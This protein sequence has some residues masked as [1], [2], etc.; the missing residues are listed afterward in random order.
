M[1]A[2]VTG[3]NGFIGSR[4][5]R[6]LLDQGYAVNGIIHTNRDRVLDTIQSREDRLTL[7][8][9]SSNGIRMAV[10]GVNEVYHLAGYYTTSRSVRDVQRLVRDNLGFTLELYAA[11]EEINPTAHTVIASSFSQLDSSGANAPET[12]YAGL[13]ALVEFGT[14]AL[15]G[16]LAALRISDTFG[17]DD[18]RPKV[19]NLCAR[20]IREG[21]SFEFRSPQSTSLALA[22]VDDVVSALMH[23]VRNG[24]T[25]AYNLLNDD[26][27]ITLGEVAATLNKDGESSLEFPR[28]DAPSSSVPFG[29]DLIP[30]W[31]PKKLPQDCLYSTLI[32]GRDL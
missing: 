4:L 22:H 6:A 7:Y 23:I 16:K 14:P 27:R 26:L 30:G 3:A 12:Y 15:D 18:P 24:Y 32:E 31:T 29:V 9:S 2:L 11:L 8:E 19:H 21:E 13:K 20:A 17:P 28:E 10:G 25:G 5:V 1:R